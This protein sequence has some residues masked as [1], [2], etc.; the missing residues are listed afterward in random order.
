MALSLAWSCATCGSRMR[1]LLPRKQAASVIP[2][3]RVWIP[4][5]CTACGSP[6]EIEV[7]ETQPV[8]GLTTK[9]ERDE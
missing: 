8:E 2:M 9:P 3:K 4:V 7:P 1:T 6:R 5:R